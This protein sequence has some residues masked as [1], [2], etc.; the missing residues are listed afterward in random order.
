MDILWWLRL[1]GTD[2]YD[3]TELRIMKA[4]VTMASLSLHS[5]HDLSEE[6][7]LPI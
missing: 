4:R 1:R 5:V 7:R 3:N 2:S 6:N